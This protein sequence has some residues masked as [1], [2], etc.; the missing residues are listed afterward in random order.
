MG[1]EPGALEVVRT[2]GARRSLSNTVFPRVAAIAAAA[3]ARESRGGDMIV[4]V[5]DA[6]LYCSTRGE[7]PVCLVLSGIGTKPYERQI[8]E[9]LGD[10]LKLVF[11]DLRG[12]GRSTGDP[13]SLTFDV[14]AADLEAIRT[15]LGVERVAVL[16]HSVLG[17]LAIEYGR[18]CPRTVSHVV[19]VGAPTHGDITRLAK[20]TSDFFAEHASEERK[21]ILE[22]NLEKLPEG[23]PW[24]DGFFAQTPVRFFDPNFD[25][26]PLFAE[27]DFKPELLAHLMWAIVPKWDVRDV[28]ASLHVPT[29]LAHGRHDYTVPWMHWQGIPPLFPN[30]TLEIFERSGHQPFVEEPERFASEVTDW[31]ARQ[32]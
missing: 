22:E 4:Q 1:V 7:G 18:L 24:I 8:P 2:S 27:L 15:E 13:T 31:M 12:S 29:L 30:A 14:L 17:I 11:V 6:E 16:G 26:A 5:K 23:A 10:H 32:G 25:V 20:K 28:A 21:R 19:A 9:A 3:S